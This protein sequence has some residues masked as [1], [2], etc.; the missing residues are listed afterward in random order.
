M[1]NPPKKI[2]LLSLFLVLASTNQAQTPTETAKPSITEAEFLSIVDKKEEVKGRSVAAVL[3]VRALRSNKSVNISDCSIEGD[4]VVSGGEVPSLRIN[5]SEVN[6]EINFEGTTFSGQLTISGRSIFK[7]E[8]VFRNVSFKD[9][10]TVDAFVVFNKWF[11]A[12]LCK[13][14]EQ[15]RLDNV[16][17][18]G[19]GSFNESTFNK[20]AI[21]T[22]VRSLE[23]G[24]YF[25]RAVFQDVADFSSAVFQE[26]TEFSD[27]TFNGN[28]YFD[29]AQFGGETDFSDTKF[30]KSVSFSHAKVFQTLYFGQVSFSGDAHFDQL[31]RGEESLSGKLDF[32]STSFNGRVFLDNSRLHTLRFSNQF[33][34]QR[35]GNPTIFAKRLIARN[36]G[37]HVADFTEVEFRDYVDFSNAS[38]GERLDLTGASFD[39]EV[40]FY[41]ARFPPAGWIENRRTGISLD[42]VK[43][44]RTVHLDYSQLT[45]PPPWWKVW[46]SPKSRIINNDITTWATLERIFQNTHK[47]DSQNDALYQKRSIAP[48]SDGP[49]YENFIPNFFEKAFWGY[50]VRPWRLFF[51]IVLVFGVFT[52]IYFTQTKLLRDLS[53]RLKFALHFSWRTSLTLGYGYQQSRTT[54]FKWLTLIHSIVFKIMVLCLL[55]AVANVSPLLNDLIGKLLPT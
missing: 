19:G 33:N 55:K 14:S 44:D 50:G 2:L 6:G 7:G 26:E 12:Y 43:F 31:N 4:I 27:S 54:L 13:F 42:R 21:F 36:L 23:R 30:S 34:N 29:H 32:K 9:L 45:E 15:V 11:E 37:C 51:W 53:E 5:D 40:D 39:G 8:V 41:R 48:F 25:E 10:F 22:Y 20:L 24:P 52:A 49:D 16:T 38:F 47:G 46:S 1:F 35:S 17:L 18:N 3:I 28:V